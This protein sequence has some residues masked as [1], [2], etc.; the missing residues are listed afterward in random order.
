[1]RLKRLALLA[2]LSGCAAPRLATRLPTQP[3]APIEVQI[4]AFNDFH[5]NIVPPPPIEVTAPDGSTSMLASG[6]VARLAA[7]LASE[8]RGHLLTITVSAGD[9]IGASPLVSGA[10]LDEPTI[11]AMNLVG[12]DLNAV[13]NHE[14]DKGPRELW[15]M[16]GGGCA[17]F[18]T[19]AP[20]RLEPFT[21]AKFRFLAANVRTSDGVTLF[22][23]T[24]IRQFGIIRIGFIG[25]T[26]KG[27]DNLVSPVNS[28]GLSFADEVV[29]A[30]ALVPELKA[31][32]VDTIVL[33]IHQGGRT[34]A[35]TTGQGCD[36]LSG[37]ILPIVDRLDSAIA[38]VVSGHTHYAYVCQRGGKLLTSAGKYGYLF[39]NL[40]LLF[41]PS[42]HALINQSAANLV[43]GAGAEEPALKA[44]VD[45]YVEAAAPVANRVIGH[46][47]GPAPRDEK[48][49]ESPAADLNADAFLDAG[50]AAGAKLAL[51]NATGVRVALIPASDGSITYGQAFAM[52][53][54]T[55]HV[56]VKS[57]TGAQLKALLEQQ[58]Q[59]SSYPAG[60]TPSQLVPSVGFGFD[61]DLARPAG[62]RIVA[63]RLNGR[64]IAP[65][66]RYRVAVNNYLANGG[67]GFSVFTQ[68]T[69]ASD[70]G[71]DIDA[72][73]GWLAKGQRVPPVGRVR[74]LTR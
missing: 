49:R 46:L 26:L 28:A 33:L 68:V 10:F 21:G 55:N 18:T 54:F 56:V 5:G 19:L 43:T 34:P 14:F 22:A 53:P 3:A 60:A 73:A 42:T 67:D 71:L 47:S 1:M 40:R 32:G 39:S 74:N 12:L 38:T 8:R 48:D 17:K 24:A 72:L 45:R 4:L 37:D 50:K 30:N 35:F 62:S 63:I 66:A 70:A 36:G 61:Y 9:L 64:A 7:A 15:R 59:A 31:A 44:L 41:D 20:C 65:T 27:T 16:Q 51:V 58:F 11:A 2:L 23:P 13:G 57:L 6:G 69:G 52:M 25:M 29:T